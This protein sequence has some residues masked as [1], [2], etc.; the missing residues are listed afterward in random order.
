M[1]RSSVHHDNDTGC[2]G[3]DN[4]ANFPKKPALKLSLP[5]PTQ[6][7]PAIPAVTSVRLEA[8]H[9]PPS[10][11]CGCAT[12]HSMANTSPRDIRRR[13]LTLPS[14]NSLGNMITPRTGFAIAALPGILML[15]LFYS[16]VIHMHQS[17][18]RWPTSI[19]EN[20]FSPA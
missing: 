18:G 4:P 9:H 7:A 12:Y 16:L 2:S 5:L 15:A 10:H 11:S 14:C 20:G 1:F 3:A 6:Q 13:V 8:F 17:L 19:G